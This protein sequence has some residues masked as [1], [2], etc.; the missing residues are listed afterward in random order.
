MPD[1]LFMLVKYKYMLLFLNFADKIS[2]LYIMGIQLFD[3]G[4]LHWV[5]RNFFGLHI[6]YII[7][8]NII[9]NVYKS[10]QFCG[11]TLLALHGPHVGHATVMSCIIH[12]TLL[13]S[14][15]RISY[16]S[17]AISMMQ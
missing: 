1:E 4:E 3:L 12:S 7:V 16:H 13:W 6:K 11:A 8:Y 9:V 15:C 10:L 2:I 17:G 14:D 5:K